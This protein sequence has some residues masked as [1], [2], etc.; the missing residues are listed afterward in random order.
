PDVEALAVTCRF[1]D[2]R[3]DREPGCALRA[4][5]LS[6]ELPQARLDSYRKLAR[7]AA[8]EARRTDPFARLEQ[9]RRA[10]QRSRAARRN[11]DER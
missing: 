4:A 8:I 6:G 5:V 7:E 1:R 11:R 2:C 10:K 3:H 9:R